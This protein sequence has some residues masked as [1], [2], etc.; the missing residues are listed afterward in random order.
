MVKLDTVYKEMNYV[1]NQIRSVFIVP[2]WLMERRCLL[3]DTLM[4]EMVPLHL[5][6]L[7]QINSE[8]G[9]AH[10]RKIY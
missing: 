8:R 4:L 6:A 5:S 1:M 10:A 9:E 3:S 2:A 7:Y